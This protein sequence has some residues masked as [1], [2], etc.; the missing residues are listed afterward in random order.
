[1]PE[2]ETLAQEVVVLDLAPGLEV[3]PVVLMEER[4]AMEEGGRRDQLLTR[5]TGREGGR[6]D[7][8]RRMLA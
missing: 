4:V 2:E 6:R 7:R 5:P 3:L 8:V 1:M